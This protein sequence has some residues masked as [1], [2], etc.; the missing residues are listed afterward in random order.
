MILMQIMGVF[1]IFV[2]GQEW[3]LGQSLLFLPRNRMLLKH[4]ARKRSKPPTDQLLIQS[5][6]VNSSTFPILLHNI[7]PFSAGEDATATYPPL[8][9]FD[10]GNKNYFVLNERQLVVVVSVTIVY[11]PDSFRSRRRRRR[12]LRRSSERSETHGSLRWET[13]AWASRSQS[14]A[15]TACLD[16]T[17]I[18]EKV[19]MEYLLWHHYII[20]ESPIY[21]SIAYE[22]FTVNESY[23]LR[24]RCA[25]HLDYTELQWTRIRRRC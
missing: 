25:C 22:H 24:E 19:R 4:G 10:S 13:G 2:K 21:A 12:W 5:L 7:P 17:S 16:G 11:R 14:P 3:Q 9:I 23:V 18:M 20:R 6:A 1:P 8:L 15:S